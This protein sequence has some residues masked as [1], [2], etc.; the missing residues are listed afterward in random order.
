MNYMSGKEMEAKKK[1]MEDLARKLIEVVEQHDDIYDWS[2]MTRFRSVGLKKIAALARHW[3]CIE[4]AKDYVNE[5]FASRLVKLGLERS[6][7]SDSFVKFLLARRHGFVEKQEVE[8]KVD[9]KVSFRDV[10]SGGADGQGN[11]EE[12]PES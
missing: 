4:E 7:M 6:K 8:M 12:E 10:I 3:K 2:Q 1:E 5:V 11:A 9:Q